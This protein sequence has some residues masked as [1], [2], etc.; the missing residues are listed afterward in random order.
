MRIEDQ[1]GLS[2]FLIPLKKFED[3]EL[4]YNRLPYRKFYS[5]GF[6]MSHSGFHATKTS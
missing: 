1:V 4:I 2:K 5:R 3:T 6:R